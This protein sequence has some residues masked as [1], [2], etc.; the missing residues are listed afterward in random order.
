M[1]E[2]VERAASAAVAGGVWVVFVTLTLRHDRTQALADL[3]TALADS[4]RKAQQGNGFKLYKA[5]SGFLGAVRSMEVRYSLATGWHPHIH[6]LAFFKCKRSADALFYGEELAQRYL[7]KLNAAGFTA[8]RS[9]QDVQLCTDPEGAGRYAAKGALELANGWAKAYDGE[10]NRSFHPFELV[11][12]GTSEAVTGLPRAELVERFK[13]YASVFPGT[14]QCR[15]S[16]QLA[17][18]LGIE[19]SED[20]E[21][22]GEETHGDGLEPV[23]LT[24]AAHVWRR[25]IAGGHAG[26]FLAEYAVSEEPPDP[27]GLFRKWAELLHLR[28]DPDLCFW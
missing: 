14:G 16:R 12:F 20:E 1:Q 28:D 3:K 19:P 25:L 13:E 7:A 22:P 10:R 2:R 6:A 8:T 11:H 15:I 21:N 27:G 18:A 4:Y 23:G 9:G 26:R 5:R 24:V 17:D